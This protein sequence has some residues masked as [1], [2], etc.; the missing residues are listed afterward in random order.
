VVVLMVLSFWL[1]EREVYERI[2]RRR[3]QLA[4]HAAGKGRR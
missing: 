4:R 3:Q 1:G 2:V